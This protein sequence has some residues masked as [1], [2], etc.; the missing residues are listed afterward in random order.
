M[1]TTTAT[2]RTMI[3]DDEVLAR[4]NVEALLRSDP[5]IALVAQCNNGT[6][7]VEAIKQHQPDLL[8][9][10]VQLLRKNALYDITH[11]Q[12]A[13]AVAAAP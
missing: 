5:D 9:L 7:A 8:F 12:H 6:Q 1:N 2:I 10:D 13:H 3:V 11:R 4:Q